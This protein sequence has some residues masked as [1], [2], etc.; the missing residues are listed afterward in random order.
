[1]HSGIHKYLN[2]KFPQN[3]LIR[4]PLPGVVIIAAFCFGFL[5]TYKPL[6]FGPSRNFSYEFTMAFYSIFSGFAAM[7]TALI[8]RSFKWFSTKV[9]WTILKELISILLVISGTGIAIYLVGFIMEMPT[10]R[11][12]INIFLDSFGNTFLIGIF[13]FAFFT[14][15]NYRYLFPPETGSFQ[16]PGINSIQNKT[17]E[18]RVQIT[19]QLKKESLSFNPDDLIYA[20]SDGNYV[21]FYLTLRNAV[22]KE[23]IRNSIN[24]I[25]KQLSEIPYFLR[26][27]RAFIVNLKKVISKQGTTLGY[28]LK[29]SGTEARIPVSRNNTK[30][31]NSRFSVHGT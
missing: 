7:I 16:N 4:K 17:V 25:E 29:L 15:I 13:P 31:F 12:N 10:K 2:H 18:D 20:E 24:N 3:Y 19:S 26:T 6:G 5:L 14:L 30:H 23:I 8:I 28:T 22:K 1:M 21:I 9:D 27:H 11:W